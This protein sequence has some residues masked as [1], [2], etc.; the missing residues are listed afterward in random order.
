MFYR[1]LLFLTCNKFQYFNSGYEST[2]CVVTICTSL[3]NPFFW[4]LKS[5]FI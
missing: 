4:K 1:V 3:L 2:L 5:M